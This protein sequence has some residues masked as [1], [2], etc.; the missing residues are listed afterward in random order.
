MK[1]RIAIGIVIYTPQENL[2]DRIRIIQESSH[3]IYVFDNSPEIGVVGEFC[4]KQ[5]NCRY[6]TYGSNV[7]LGIGISALCSEAFNEGHSALL[8]FDQD[9]FFSGTTLSFVQ[10]F[11]INN[12]HLESEYS[13][14]VFNAKKGNNPGNEK[15]SQVKNVFLAISSGSLFFLKN[16]KEMG[17]HN[18]GYFVDCVDYEF[19]LNSNNN[20]FRIGEVSSTPGFDHQTGQEDQEYVFLKKKMLLRPYKLARMS[21]AISAYFKLIMASLFSLNIRYFLLFIKSMLIYIYYQI[22]VRILAF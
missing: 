20:N 13:A 9:T 1:S 14:I 15:G 17:W 8:F 5:E 21:D 2:I 18:T 19:C 3:T 4:R 11:Y 22:L 10:E 6:I 16:L 12:A 7:G